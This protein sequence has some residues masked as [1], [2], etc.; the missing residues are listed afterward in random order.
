ML[1]ESGPFWLTVDVDSPTFIVTT[2]M[3]ANISAGVTAGYDPYSSSTMEMLDNFRY[4][5][6]T[7][8]QVGYYASDTIC[9]YFDSYQGPL[10]GAM[11]VGPSNMSYNFFG[12]VYYTSTYSPFQGLIGLGPI[13]SPNYNTNFLSQFVKANNNSVLQNLW[14]FYAGPFLNN[15]TQLYIGGIKQ[16]LIAV[17]ND[18]TY[19]LHTYNVTGNNWTVPL[20]DV[21]QSNYSYFLA[22]ET[23]KAYFNYQVDGLYFPYATY[24]KLVANLTKA[25]PGLVCN[26]TNY[27]SCVYNDVCGV[28]ASKVNAFK[29]A[30]GDGLVYS[31]PTQDESSDSTNAA[32]CLIKIGKQTKGAYVTLGLPFMKAFYTVYNVTGQTVGI[33]LSTNSF[34]S[35]AT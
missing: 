27:T 25:I 10:N 32:T 18:S 28:I 34:G 8:N 33:A 3:A 20:T 19:G 31:V 16:S 21:R 6:G 7:N 17:G 12:A 30:F 4:R 29:F 2:L 11:M 35:V 13:S 15:Q 22:N 23:S 9:Y 24:T 1:G 14:S 26:S 5:D